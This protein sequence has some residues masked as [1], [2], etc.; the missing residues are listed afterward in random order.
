M[1]S[2]RGLEKL[3]P[4]LLILYFILFFLKSISPLISNKIIK[5]RWR[6]IILNINILIIFIFCFLFLHRS[7]TNNFSSQNR[8][9]SSFPFKSTPTF[10]TTPKPVFS[11]VFVPYS[12]PRTTLNSQNVFN[13]FLRNSSPS[14]IVRS[15]TPF[16]STPL[17]VSNGF[18]VTSQSPFSIS[19]FSPRSTTKNPYD[20]SD[21]D[22]RKRLRNYETNVLGSELRVLAFGR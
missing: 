1:P 14:P 20:F 17:R 13:D 3:G 11:S 15:S 10:R 22:P 12:S 7:F 18:G 8:F 5:S 21:F 19:Q 6:F 16:F 2:F 9:S 4:L